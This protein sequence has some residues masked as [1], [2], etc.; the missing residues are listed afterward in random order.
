MSCAKSQPFGRT[1]H[2]LLSAWGNRWR[3]VRLAMCSMT[4]YIDDSG[5]DPHQHVAIATA[6]VIPAA[7]ILALEREWNSLKKNEGFSDFHMSEFSARNRKSNFDWEDVKHDRVYRRVR[8]IIKKYGVR[9]ASFAIYKKDYDEAIPADLRQYPGQFHYSWAIRHM[10]DF[11]LQWRMQSG[12]ETPL[13]YIFDWM[14]KNDPRRIEV[15]EIIDQQQTAADTL[16]LDRE[17]ENYSFR[18]REDIPGLQCVDVLAWI[19]YQSALLIFRNK[20][21]FPDAKTGLDD[22]TKHLGGKWRDILFIKRSQLEE[23][24]SNPQAVEH[25]KKWFS[26]WKEKKLAP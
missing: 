20:P 17:F 19:S 10:L 18:H 25:T 13:E 9:T 15:E 1:H 14:K 23:W 11:L 3:K 6:L 5:T 4:A 26:E 8:Q 7:R 21:L 12:V 2:M 24:A 22:F 16:G